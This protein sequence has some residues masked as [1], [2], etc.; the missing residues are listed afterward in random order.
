MSRISVLA[1]LLSSLE[2]QTNAPQGQAG[3]GPCVECPWCKH[4]FPPTSQESVAALEKSSQQHKKNLKD[5]VMTLTK[6][7]VMILVQDL[8]KV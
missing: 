3:S 1:P 8:E 2:E 7:L 6:D 5:L 4:T